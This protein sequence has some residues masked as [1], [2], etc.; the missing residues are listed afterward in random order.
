MKSHSQEALMNELRQINWKTKTRKLACTLFPAAAIAL[1]LALALPCMAA[2]ARAIKSKVA[3]AYPEVAKRLRIT[4]E[5]KMEATVDP[6]GKVTGVKTLSGNTMLSVAAEDAVRKWRFAS[7]P[8]AS[9]V[10][11]NVNFGSAE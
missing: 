3:P 8:V 11:V 1:M 4:G 7:G 2:D 9:T 10:E 5:V 6:D